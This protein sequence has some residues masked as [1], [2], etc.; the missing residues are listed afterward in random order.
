M[1]DLSPALECV[2]HLSN[3][4]I[5]ARCH[6]LVAAILVSWGGSSRGAQCARRRRQ[7]IRDASGAIHRLVM[8][9]MLASLMLLVVRCSC[10]AYSVRGRCCLCAHMHALSMAGEG[11]RRQWGGRKSNH[12]SWCSWRHRGYS[13]QRAVERQT[14]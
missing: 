3:T 4:H 5:L 1:P 9:C 7:Y 11:C 10:I 2:A 12:S 13:S 8:L 14:W 6:T